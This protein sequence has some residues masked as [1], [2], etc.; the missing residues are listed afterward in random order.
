MLTRLGPYQNQPCGDR[1]G[2]PDLTA[3]A[4]QDS[5]G[6][7]SAS[8][9]PS[10]SG[11][12]G[13]MPQAGIAGRPSAPG[14]V[15]KMADAHVPRVFPWKLEYNCPVHENW[16]I[17]HTGMLIPDLVQ[18]YICSENCLRGVIM[19]AAEMGA[20]SRISSVM[21]TER[22]AASG[23]LEEVS[24]E[25]VTDLINRFPKRPRAVMVFLVCMHHIVGADGRYIFRELG[26]RFPDIDFLPCWMDPIMQK[27]GLTPE[28]KQRKSMMAVIPP[29][30]AQMPSCLSARLP[31][32]LRT[33]L[34]AHLRTQ[35]PSQSP[36]QTPAHLRTQCP[37]QSPG[38]TPAHLRTQWPSQ[39]P[40]QMPAHSPADGSRGCHAAVLGDNLR[41][42]ETSDI[43]RLLGY[44]GVG[45]RQVMDCET[46]DEYLGMGDSFLYLTRSA[47]SVYGLKAL[48]QRHGRPVLY[49]PP[50]AG[51]RQI[52]EELRK[53]LETVED[54]ARSAE[55]DADS[56]AGKA[57]GAGAPT[58]TDTDEGKNR[59]TGAEEAPGR[60]DLEALLGSFLK[61]ERARTE[62]AF[63]EARKVVGDTEI[64]MDYIAFPRPLSFAGRLLE[65]G[66]RVTRV[67]MDSVS[68]EEEEDFFRLKKECPGLEL[69]STSHV[70]AR[71]KHLISAAARRP[72][73][74]E[75]MRPH[76]QEPCGEVKILALGPKAAFFADTPYFVNW[77]E[78]GGNW[79]YDGLRKLASAMID[80]YTVPKDT[81]DL[82]QRK[83]LGL[84]S[85]VERAQESACPEKAGGA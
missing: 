44:M 64:W 84:L 79:G 81:R 23:R 45:T 63:A 32:H 43:V 50:V 12:A 8:C 77:I 6:I 2:R 73:G 42:P 28:Q 55:K 34:P 51:D 30:P 53:L 20:A 18:I 46:Y 9:S 65:E 5:P 39:S 58:A 49:L 75:Y 21:P 36:G 31:G 16:N 67:C 61:V 54:A 13:D 74:G 27:V 59:G 22:E 78:N 7:F 72:G 82:V 25:G 68:P 26:K 14:A 56:G 71:Q 15:V 4:G 29:L 76:G 52:E 17:V 19:T 35:W 11:A 3:Y 47:L 66:F 70:E 10:V 85:M 60:E 1:K 24:I 80:A 57:A 83:G 40:G 62:E 69:L 33:D 48:G 38:Q 37:S 41:L